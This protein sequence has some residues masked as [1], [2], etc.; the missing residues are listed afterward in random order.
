MSA[1][2]IVV[3]ENKHTRVMQIVRDLRRKSRAQVGGGRVRM[4]ERDEMLR[5]LKDRHL[6]YC[7]H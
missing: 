6:W 4:L 1:E 7:S 2:A 5:C 3:H